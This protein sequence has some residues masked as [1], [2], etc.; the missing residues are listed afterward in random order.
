MKY[1]RENRDSHRAEPVYVGCPHCASPVYIGRE[2]HR[3]RS[4]VANAIYA[5]LEGDSKLKSDVG[6]L[7]SD[8]YEWGLDDTERTYPMSVLYPRRDEG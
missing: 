7:A 1:P 6:S 3:A 5:R 8:S 2:L 4:E